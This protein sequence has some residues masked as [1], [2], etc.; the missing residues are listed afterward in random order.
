MTN[1]SQKDRILKLLKTRGVLRPRDLDSLNVSREYL[2]KLYA[3]GI[4]DRPSRGLYS[5]PETAPSEY[6]SYVEACQRVPHGII[7]LLSALRFHDLTTQSPFEIWMA[8]GEKARH[9]RVDYPI[10]RIFRFSAGSLSF[11]VQKKQVEGITIQVYSPAKTVADCFKYRNKIGLDVAIEA[12][13]DCRAKRAATNDQL[14][15]AAKICRMTNVMR[16][17]LEAV[18]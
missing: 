6:R 12:L 16:P 8:I 13:R 1:E 15:E 17:Y 11:G 4:L 5:L 7:C 10:L 18:S 14:W 2:N 3:Q 9:P